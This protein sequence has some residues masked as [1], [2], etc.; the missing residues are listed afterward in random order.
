M[1]WM[2]DLGFTSKIEKKTKAAAD[3]KAY[4]VARGV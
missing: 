3:V 2:K 4:T 1:D